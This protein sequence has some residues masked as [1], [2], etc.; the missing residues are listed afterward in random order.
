[1]CGLFL[2]ITHTTN[3][4]VSGVLALVFMGGFLAATFWPFVTSKH[5]MQVTRWSCK[6]AEAT[7]YQKPNP[8]PLACLPAMASDHPSP[9]L[10]TPPHG[11]GGTQDLP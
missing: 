10:A 5:T 6:A 7:P 8:T 9:P 3:F 4:A 2:S 11:M 1:M